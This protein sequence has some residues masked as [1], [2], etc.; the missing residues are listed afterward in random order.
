MAAGRVS[1]MASFICATCGKVH[2]GL[3]ALT[4]HAPA[5]YDWATPEERAGDWVLQSDFCRFK[6]V[7]F[8]VRCVLVLPIIGSDQTLEF[9]AWSTLSKTNIDRYWDTFEDAD[10]SKLGV[11]FGYFANA[12]P[13][14]PQTT[15][16]M[17]DVVPQDDRQRPLI[18]LHEADHPL[19]H[20]QRNGISFDEAM[21]YYHAHMAQH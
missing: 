1:E 13:G 20:H 9:G 14:Y 21:A 8:Y 3:A 4:F 15:A 19:V 2:N 12:I 5:P 18:K 6:D 7:D 16:L 17:C 11:M 10:Q